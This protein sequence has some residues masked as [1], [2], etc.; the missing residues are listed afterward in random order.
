M[1]YAKLNG[2]RLQTAPKRV[3]HE[4]KQIYNPPDKILTEL[5]YY[6]V[7]YTDAPTDAP[8]GQH[9]ESYWEQGETEILQVWSLV[10]DPAYEESEE[11]PTLT[12]LA[13]AVERGI[14]S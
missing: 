4:G 10:D 13:E 2:S 6:P 5:G 1:K 8:E 7:T 3:L 12:D 9:Y 11:E 14:N